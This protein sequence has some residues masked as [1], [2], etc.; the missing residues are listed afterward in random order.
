MSFSPLINQ[1]ITAFRRLPGVG[2]KSAQRMA[3]HLL[4]HDREGGVAIANALQ[5]TMQHVGHCQRCRTFC[6][7]DICDICTNRR[8]DPGLLCVVESPADVIAIEQA[9]SFRGLYFVLMGHL[10]PLDGI[11]PEKLGIEPL[12]Q[13]LQTGEIKELILATNATVEGETTAFYIAKIAAEH[14]VPASR[15][16]HGVPLGSE[17]EY[18]D[19]GTLADALS[20]RLT[21]QVNNET[22]HSTN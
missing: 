8:R 18:I 20:G 10:S 15:I 2:P 12:T 7:L 5:Q 22:T 11:G 4:E 17:I 19:G 13:R 6:E 21:I 1:L 9:G 3:F 16:A 14:Q